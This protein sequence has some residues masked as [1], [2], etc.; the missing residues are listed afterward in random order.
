MYHAGDIHITHLYLY[1]VDI[2][3]FIKLYLVWHSS[4]KEDNAPEGSGQVAKHGSPKVN[5]A[6][7]RAATS[8]PALPDMVVTV[9][10]RGK[11][12]L[13]VAVHMGYFKCLTMHKQRSID[14]NNCTVGSLG[15]SHVVSEPSIVVTAECS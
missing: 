7:Y 4:Y 6:P 14:T 2:C 5:A 11:G 10:R 3:V 9:G 13:F 15:W 12:K 8:P 1:H